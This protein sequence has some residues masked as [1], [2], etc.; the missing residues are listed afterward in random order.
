MKSFIVSIIIAVCIAAGSIFYM[1][2]LTSASETLAD[3]NTQ[4]AEALT[5]E[6]Y[7]EAYD[8]IAELRECM[9]S[10]RK[11]MSAFGNHEEIDKI[12]SNILEMER[13]TRSRFK[14]D[15]LAKNAVLGMLF[16]HLPQNYRLRWENIF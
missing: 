4:I 13:Y 15:A 7:S 8:K 11:Y 16:E 1:H 12:Y 5:E 9:D 3:I 6:D 14:D 2:S 10:K